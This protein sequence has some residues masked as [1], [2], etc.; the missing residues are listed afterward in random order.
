MKPT[1]LSIGVVDASIA[2]KARNMMMPAAEMMV[3]AWS[4]AAITADRASLPSCQ[5]SMTESIRKMS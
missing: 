4:S 1:W 3:P 5:C 2:E